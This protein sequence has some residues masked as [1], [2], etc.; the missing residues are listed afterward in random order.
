MTFII[1]ASVALK[2]FAPEE[3]RE[4]ALKLLEDTS[5]L[6]APD[7]IIPEV[8]NIAWKKWR[9]GNFSKIQA[10]SAAPSILRL[11]AFIHPS[12][13][14]HVRAIN[15]SLA[16]DHPAYDCFYLACA[17]LQ[18]AILVTAD[19]KFHEKVGRSE[20]KSLV[21]HLSEILISNSE[22]PS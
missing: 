5:L 7:L 14:L 18:A 21:C 13:D 3:G 6:E 1:D 10:E 2:W 20:F 11:I 4:K 9:Q 8:T 22:F 15:M 17:E 12:Q 19:K 16:L